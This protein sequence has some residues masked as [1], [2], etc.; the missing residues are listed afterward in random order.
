MDG[1]ELD[2]VLLIGSA[3]LLFAILA[4]RLSVIAGLPSLLLYLGLGL[5]LGDAVLGIEF[6]DPNLAH[7]LGFA[8]LVLI[9]AEGGLTTKLEEIRPTIR[10]GAL[11]ASVGVAVSV[12]VMTLGVHYLL[13]VDWK[14]A[15]LL[16][17]VTSPT[18]AAAVFSVLRTVPLKRSILGVLESESGFNDAPTVLLVIAVSAGTIDDHG[19]LVFVALIIVELIVGGLT[20]WLVGLI[21]SAS[22]RRVALPSAGLYPIAVL[23]F[24]VLAYG[25]ATGIHTSGFA[26]VYVAALVLGNAE[27]PHRVATRSFAEGIGWL[28]QIGLF[29]MLGLLAEPATLEWWHLWTA[30]AAGAILTFVA[31]PLSVAVCAPWFAVTW[32]EQVFLG[33]AGLRGA[34]PIVLATIPLAAGVAFSDDLFNVVFIFVIVSTIFQAPTLGAVARRCGVIDADPLRD[35]DIEAAPLERISADL[36]QIHVS[37]DSRLIGVEVAELRL[38]PGASV[39]IVVRDGETLVP[40]STTRIQ[41]GDD[42]LVVSPRKLRE[43][44]E[45][46]LRAIARHGRLAGWRDDT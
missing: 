24:T 31:R 12:L 40:R 30:L 19:P 14:L 10:I 25:A 7:A 4:V 37:R 46:R 9:L 8:A 11:L 42:I 36:V 1:R 2:S 16:A 29:V 26:A 28:A 13:G 27:L 23:A 15:I 38:P 22:L 20:G 21:G 45:N 3:V 33:W 44:T 5:V 18:D 39:S 35:V 6:S 41:S 43:A 17:A 34:V 32:R